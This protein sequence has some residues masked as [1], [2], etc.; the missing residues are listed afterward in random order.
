M[1]NLQSV[2]ILLL[3]GIIIY[4]KQCTPGIEYEKLVTY[5]THTKIDTIPFEYPVPRYVK[6]PVYEP[7]SSKI[8]PVDSTIINNYESTFSDSL[9]TGTLHASVKG[10]LLDLSMN[11]TPKFPKYIKETTT[12]KE[13]LP[14]KSMVF[15][16]TNAYGNRNEIFTNFGVSYYNKRG[17]LYNATYDPVNKMY[18][19]GVGLKIFEL[20]K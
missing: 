9:L 16:T 20:K 6:I 4:L 2:I 10:T 14:K 15:L 8:D 3:I 12:I 7:V 17:M 13:T 1:N 18:G 5:E 11:Y 19:V